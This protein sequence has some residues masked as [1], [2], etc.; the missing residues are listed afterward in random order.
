MTLAVDGPLNN[1]QTNKQNV[2]FTLFIDSCF[3]LYV[4]WRFVKKW[5]CFVNTSIMATQLLASKHAGESF[6]KR[7]LK[8]W[9]RI[10]EKAGVEEKID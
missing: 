1:K 8:E 5:Q 6:L 4:S 7:R 2:I 3:L 9:K 10:Q